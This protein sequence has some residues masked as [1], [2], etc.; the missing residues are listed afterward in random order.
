MLEVKEI[1]L[2]N[3]TALGIK[4]M[5]DEDKPL[6]V[7]IKAGKGFIVCS[8]FNMKSLDEKGVIA[9]RVSGIKSIE[10][11]LEA[12]IVEATSKADEIGIKKGMPVKECLEKFLSQD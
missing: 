7:L 2:N 1:K 8:N 6:M 10:T 9:G 3:G 4:V 5:K 11:A 12:N